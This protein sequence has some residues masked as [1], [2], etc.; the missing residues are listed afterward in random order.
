MMV[1]PADTVKNGFS[2]SFI[3]VINPNISDD[4][5]TGKNRI[6]DDLFK[7]SEYP[8]KTRILK[9]NFCC[10]TVSLDH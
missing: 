2:V 8:Q 6:T 1:H 4:E 9:T 10:I 3:H 7:V 5:D